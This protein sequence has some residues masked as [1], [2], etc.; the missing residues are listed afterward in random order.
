MSFH[1]S[2]M[3]TGSPMILPSSRY[4]STAISRRPLPRIRGYE[5][6]ELEYERETVGTLCRDTLRGCAAIMQHME[7]QPGFWQGIVYP[8]ANM[9]LL[10]QREITEQVSQI[11]A[12]VRETES[13]AEDSLNR[14]ES[15]LFQVQMT[16]MK[17]A[18]WIR[19]IVE[20]RGLP[21][22]VLRSES[23]S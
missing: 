1:E 17:L 5:M 11:Y 13:R 8:A 9:T 23:D 2:G 6:Y 12:I 21:V 20:G 19:L 7:G 16:F 15:V 10:D 3:R 4:G 18:N 14:G 22:H